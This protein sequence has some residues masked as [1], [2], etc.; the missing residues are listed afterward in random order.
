MEWQ[1][2]ILTSRI[3]DFEFFKDLQVFD[4]HVGG[5]LW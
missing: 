3:L 2:S 4:E 1:N 5:F